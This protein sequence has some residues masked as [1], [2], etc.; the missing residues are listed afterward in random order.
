MVGPRRLAGLGVVCGGGASTIS[1]L[2]AIAP[3]GVLVPAHGVYAAKVY[4]ENGDSRMA[5]T[6]IGVR[7]T[8][9]DGDRVTVEGFILDFDGGWANVE[10]V[11][12]KKD[13][14]ETRLIPL[15]S[16]RTITILPEGGEG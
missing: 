16:I 6:N 1:A 12:E 9:D 13:K 14:R 7:P 15:S 5:V 8:V 11:R 3:P 2:P 10:F 4:F